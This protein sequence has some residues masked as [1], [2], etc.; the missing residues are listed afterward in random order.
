M[1]TNAINLVMMKI[2]VVLFAILGA[3]A[4]IAGAIFEALHQIPAG[5]LCFAVAAVLRWQLKQ[6]KKDDN[7]YDI[8]LY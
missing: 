4:I 7:K 2:F 8:D 3:T 6:D 5:L 1:N